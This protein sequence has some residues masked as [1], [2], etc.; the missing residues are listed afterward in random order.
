[1]ANI[2]SNEKNCKRDQKRKTQRHSQKSNLK[3]QIK[4]TKTTKKQDDLNLSYKKIDSAV[5][6]KL[7]TKNKSNRLK[8][9]LAKNNKEE[10]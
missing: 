6:K 10:K 4:K 5:S 8:S 9:R 2:K 1:M 7:I 3:T